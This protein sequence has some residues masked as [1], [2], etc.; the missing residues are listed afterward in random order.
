M[1]EARNPVVLDVR[2]PTLLKIAAALALLW[3]LWTLSGLILLLVVAVILAV[4]LDGPVSWI[5]R[6]GMS[7]SVAA[8]LVTGVIVVCAIGF[9]WL[10]WSSLTSQWQYLTA[11]L[12]TIANDVA[13]YVPQWLY[14]GAQASDLRSTLQ[15]YVIQTGRS[16]AAALTL[17]V[18][19]FFVTIYLLID[20]RSTL[21]WIVA[22]FP[23]RNRDKVTLTV[24]ESRA[25]IL[26]YARGNVITSLFAA[27]WVLIWML[28]LHVPAALLL[29]VIAGLADFVPVLGF[30]ASVIPA[31]A[32]ALTLSPHTAILV[33]ALWIVY[34]TI[35]NY[36]I[37]P[38]AYGK[39]LRLSDLAVILAFV[40]GAELAGVIGA[41]IALPI[42][43]LYPTVERLWL[44]EQLPRETVTEHRALS[45]RTS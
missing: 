33:V 44:R 2:I 37:A 9:V 8:L 28:V 32:L 35:E 27:V 6:R 23:L 25:V 41:L 4:A 40:A 18:L 26:A 20:G 42:A 38:W 13:G 3:C 10:T 17:I 39:N 15:T 45:R 30:I 7:R 36:F 5:E 34:H 24:N 29:A 11:Q 16:M 14:P 31:A 21:A 43:A 19:G 22:F 12:A 1:A